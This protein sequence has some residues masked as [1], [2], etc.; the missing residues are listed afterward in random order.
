MYGHPVSILISIQYGL[1][2]Y[3]QFNLCKDINLDS[4]KVNYKQKFDSLSNGE[5]LISKLLQRMR[6]F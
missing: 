2:P 4:Q 1:W 3:Q 5:E 6:Y